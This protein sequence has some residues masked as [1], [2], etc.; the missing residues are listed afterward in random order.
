MNLRDYLHFNR[1]T[2]TEFAKTVD[3]SRGHLASIVN[4]KLKPSKKLARQIEK[5]TNGQVT[6]EELLN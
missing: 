1:I 6:I 2:V 4:G 5:A 3:Y